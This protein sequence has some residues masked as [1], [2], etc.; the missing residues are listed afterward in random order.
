MP[1]THQLCMYVSKPTRRVPT[2]PPPSSLSNRV[3]PQFHKPV[4]SEE[5]LAKVC[6]ST[7]LHA[8]ALQLT[9]SGG[10]GGGEKELETLRTLRAALESVK[11][12]VDNV[13][14]DI[15]TV[16]RNCDAVAHVEARLGAVFVGAV[17]AGESEPERGKA[18][19]G[20]GRGK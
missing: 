13:H 10:G 5:S 17:G 6:F 11:Q 1:H 18:R 20:K 8:L 9:R 3:I 2:P 12:L 15:G 14:A 19:F 4:M 16:K 7:P